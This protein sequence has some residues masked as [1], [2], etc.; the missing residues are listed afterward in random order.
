V[1]LQQSHTL[2]TVNLDYD[3]FR[4]LLSTYVGTLTPDYAITY[5]FPHWTTHTTQASAAPTSGPSLDSEAT[6]A[7]GEV[8]TSNAHIS[9]GPPLCYLWWYYRNWKCSSVSSAD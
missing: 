2:L 5:E 3:V 4:P 9:L 1:D 8:R 7:E 6:A